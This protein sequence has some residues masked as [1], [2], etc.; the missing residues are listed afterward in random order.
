MLPGTTTNSKAISFYFYTGLAFLLWE[1][2]VSSTMGLYALELRRTFWGMVYYTVVFLAFGGLTEILCWLGRRILPSSAWSRQRYVWLL[3]VL[4]IFLWG[5]LSRQLLITVLKPNSIVLGYALNL[6]WI[7]LIIIIAAV[8][9]L[10]L[11]KR[12]RSG[13]LPKPARLTAYF[14]MAVLYLIISTKVSYR[15]FPYHPFSPFT[16][17][18]LLLQPAFI[19][20]AAIVV[21]LIGFLAASP[22][23]LRRLTIVVPLLLTVVVVLIA[24]FA[25][26]RHITTAAS[27]TN[28]AASQTHPNVLILLFDALRAD[29]VD[30]TGGKY[31]L[32]PAID[33]LAR[34]GK[35]YSNCYAASSWT[36]PCV[37]SL[38]SGQIRT[39][40]VS[41]NSGKLSDSTIIFTNVLSQHGYRS[42]GISANG[43]FINPRNG[44]N[45]SFDELHLINGIGYQ[46]LLLPFHTFFP[47]PIIL[48]ELA[49][50]LGFMSTNTFS[51]DWHAMNR[52][53]DRTFSQVEHKPFFMYMHYI[54]PH[55]PYV[56]K[57]YKGWLNI[58]GI[59][60]QQQTG[61]L[62]QD[63]VKITP[64]W[65]RVIHGRYMEGVQSVNEA[66]T[67][68]MEI[69]KRHELDKNTVIMITADHGEEF[70]DHGGMG[71]NRHI[72]NE[73]L[74][75]P[76]VIY[77]PPELNRELP[78]QPTGVAS[79]DIAPTVLDLAGIGND[80]PG[81][82]GRS[83]LTPNPPTH[84]PK[85]MILTQ[86]DLLWTGVVLEP[87]KLILRWDMKDG[88]ID[89]LLFNLQD[90][91]GEFHNLYPA[92]TTLADSL[93]KLL[94]KYMQPNENSG[95]NKSP[96]TR[97]PDD[98]QRLKA[99]GYVN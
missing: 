30:A 31:G 29:H 21:G 16:L 34:K 61:G 14:G 33:A 93:S 72:Y 38:F 9:N 11:A 7:P 47:Y 83:L 76:L 49:Y 45:Q 36:I 77:V 40:L 62:Q 88:M 85:F 12:E 99:L 19:L 65:E 22:R 79:V 24:N 59:I 68:M 2:L 82:I 44:F 32:T 81:G 37:A 89:T 98:L 70:L 91:A 46:Q 28:I 80:M 97:T 10:I 55:A 95:P 50:Q 20:V 84:R 96:D 41:S 39:Q 54:E 73:L 52:Q 87:Y 67:E 66:V 94:D 4:V 23:V 5:D 8:S 56:S 13:R 17:V 75:I 69:L 51:G 1:N 43:F 57:P 90:D 71:H 18:N 64:E 35:A 25:G 26:S 42:I 74:H 6:A 53:A 27:T 86:Q 78:D 3:A 58:G 63:N 60:T 15:F 92:E 48:D